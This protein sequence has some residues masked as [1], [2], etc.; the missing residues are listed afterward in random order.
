MFVRDFSAI[1]DRDGLI[2]TARCNQFDPERIRCCLVYVPTN[3]PSIRENKGGKKY[4]K[5]PDETGF[6]LLRSNL[7]SKLYTDPLTQDTY[8]AI[9]SNEVVH[10]LDPIDRLEDILARNDFP[11]LT[12]VINFFEEH[13]IERR[14]IG[15]FGSVMLNFKQKKLNDIDLILYG[16]KNHQKY[17]QLRKEMI[18][19]Y[20]YTEVPYSETERIAAQPAMA[21]A[22]IGFE[23]ILP[24]ISNRESTGL[25]KNNDRLSIKFSYLP[26]ETRPVLRFPPLEETRMEGE[27]VDDTEAFFLP[28]TY[29]VSANGRVYTIQT[30]NF[31]YFSAAFAGQKVSI[32]G[33][34]RNNS[35]RDLITLSKPYHYISPK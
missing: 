1:E 34:L 16:I 9:P 2:Y 33:T 25:I 3:L 26:E 19:K 5:I 21:N 18:S 8:P 31:A 32:F 6:T 14:F 17:I 11:L 35:E 15:L 29:K 23:L 27:V 22:P 7:P 28:Y 20:G 24:I 30:L 10:K 12:N 4:L 13:G